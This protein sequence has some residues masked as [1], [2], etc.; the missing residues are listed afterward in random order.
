MHL[1]HLKDY[2]DNM[3]DPGY[4]KLNENPS[5][6]RMNEREMFAQNMR[7][8]ANSDNNRHFLYVGPKYTEAI[9][10]FNVGINLEE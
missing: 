10:A 7:D 9:N 8:T 2:T 4:K 6:Q 1:K 3:K 5:S